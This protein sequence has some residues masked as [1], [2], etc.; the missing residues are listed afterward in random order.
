MIR[1]IPQ[2]QKTDAR[3]LQDSHD[4]PMEGCKLIEGS[5]AVRAIDVPE[6]GKVLARQFL[7][8]HRILDDALPEFLRVQRHITCPDVPE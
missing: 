8:H 4:L 7:A 3:I 1:E 2:G 6:I 5:N